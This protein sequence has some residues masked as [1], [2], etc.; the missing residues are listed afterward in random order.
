MSNQLTI[1]GTPKLFEVIHNMPLDVA[2]DTIKNRRYD[3][4]IRTSHGCTAI[5]HCIMTKKPAELLECLLVEGVDPNL[6][7][8]KDGYHASALVMALNYARVDY[9]KLLLRYG[10]NPWFKLS[11]GT[12]PIDRISQIIRE[13]PLSP[14][15]K[16][17]VALCKELCKEVLNARKRW[18]K[19][20]PP[21]LIWLC[22]YAMRRCPSRIMDEFVARFL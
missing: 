4:H 19:R 20:G 13:L 12:D 7:Y 15:R 9:V 10:A 17:Q 2:V 21:D 6:H 22:L 8:V 16:N 14:K 3:I 11:D 5:Q 1:F 18:P